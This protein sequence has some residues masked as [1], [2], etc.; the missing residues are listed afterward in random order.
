MKEKKKFRQYTNDK[1]IEII[2]DQ[3]DNRISFRACATKYNVAITS[4]V[5][6]LRAYRENGKEGQ[7]SDR[8]EKQQGKRKTVRYIKI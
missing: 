4:I 3:L 6:W 5:L 7:K 1:K 8:K 2:K